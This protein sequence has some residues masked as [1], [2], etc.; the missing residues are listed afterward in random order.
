MSSSTPTARPILSVAARDDL[1]GASRAALAI[2]RHLPEFG[3]VSSLASPEAGPLVAAWTVLAP[4]QVAPVGSARSLWSRAT[5]GLQLRST[6]T[7]AKSQDVR[8]I[9]AITLSAAPAARVIADGLGVPWVLHLRNIYSAR[10]REAPYAKYGAD[11][12]DLVLAA[13]QHIL[14]EYQ[15]AGPRT[16]QRAR[17]VLDG[18][19]LTPARPRNEAREELGL[20]GRTPTLG[21]CGAVSPQKNTL[22]A[23]SLL[24]ELPGT[25]LVVLGD[26]A[27][28]YSEEVRSIPGVLYQGFRNDAPSLL[29]GLEVLLHPSK[30]EALGLAPLEAMAAG[31]P[32]IASNV[33]GLP[34]ALGDGA[35]LLPPNDREAWIAAVRR[36]L[37]DEAFRSQLIARGLAQAQRM[38]A[39]AAAERTAAAYRELLG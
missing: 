10:G 27:A 38:S 23:A 1:Y 20:R 14:D 30:A 22:Y 24:A 5:R 33:G 7:W 36:I 39:R 17:V 15:A 19:E 4:T 2:A 9:A 6:I 8:M 11:H 32:V 26:G 18:L 12:A 34:E 16:S 25:Q 3:F 31:V 21:T 29:S 28:P 35:V 37:E 13:S